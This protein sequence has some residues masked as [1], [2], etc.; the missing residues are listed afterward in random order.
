MISSLFFWIS[1]NITK[2]VLWVLTDPRGLEFFALFT[3]LVNLVIFF[4][5]SRLYDDPED[6]HDRSR[7]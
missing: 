7:E 5:L 3:L 1:V 4:A 2:L 6:G